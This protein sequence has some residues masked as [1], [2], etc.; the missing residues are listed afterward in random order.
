MGDFDMGEPR[1][2]SDH[3]LW[4]VWSARP[5]S[6]SAGAPRLPRK[7]FGMVK[8]RTMHDPYDPACA[9]LADADRLTGV[10]RFLRKAR[11]IGQV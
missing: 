10:G 2:R 7:L 6:S 9:P 3:G 4:A 1:H 5:T 11:S 8:F